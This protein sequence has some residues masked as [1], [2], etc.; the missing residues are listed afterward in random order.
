MWATQRRTLYLSMQYSLS[1]SCL[2]RPHIWPWKTSECVF[3]YVL[4]SDFC[5]HIDN[6]FRNGQGAQ[7]MSY[8]I[9]QRA[10]FLCSVS[11]GRVIY[12]NKDA[13]WRWTIMLLKQNSLTLAMWLKDVKKK[14]QT[15]EELQQNSWVTLSKVQSRD[16][17]CSVKYKRK[18]S[19]QLLLIY[20]SA[21]LCVLQGNTVTPS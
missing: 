8:L 11:C 21:D 18:N 9:G 1:S 12:Q 10:S 15:S 20:T 17:S 13:N 4:I 5:Q 19:E 6:I 3:R 7:P 14:S 2:S 16:C